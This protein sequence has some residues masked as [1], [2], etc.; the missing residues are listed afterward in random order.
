MIKL[1]LVFAISLSFTALPGALSKGFV[2]PT[3]PLAHANT[4]PSVAWYPAGPYMDTEVAPIFSSEGAEFIQLQA[5]T[6]DLT[7]W[8]LTPTLISSLG[9]N[10]SFFVTSPISAADEFEIQ[11]M[12]ATS[13]FG[14]NFN[15]GNPLPAPVNGLS[16]NCGQD[17]R[18]GIAHLIDRTNGANSFTSTESEI[19]GVSVPLN[20]PAPPATG[21][22]VPIVCG[23]D[24]LHVQST[25]CTVNS[26]TG[27]AYN[28]AGANGQCGSETAMTACSFTYQQG[29]KSSDFCAAAD[30]F[31]AAGLATGKDANC[32]L[33]GI[34][35]IAST[36]PITI[37]GRV[38]NPPRDHAGTAIFQGICA[39]FT[40]NF[41]TTSGTSC[42]I[43]PSTSNIISLLTHGFITSFSGF[44]TSPT[45]VSQ[46][47][48]IYTG[49]FNG[50]F[51]FTVALFNSYNSGIASA[52]CTSPGTTSCAPQV[53]GGGFCSNASVGSFGANDYQYM[54]SPS[55]D[56][57]SNQM[58]FAL[59]PSGPGDPTTG[60]S[61]S[62][63]TFAACAS[64]GLGANDFALSSGST[65]SGVVVPSTGLT[66]TVPVCVTAL[67]TFSGS[68]T[69]SA[70]S[71]SPTTAA[72]AFNSGN[73]VTLTNG[74]YGCL[75]LTIT[76]T[77]GVAITAAITVSLTIGATTHTL[78]LNASVAG[79]LYSFDGLRPVLTATSAGYITA[80]IGGKEAYTIP[81]WADKSQFGYSSKYNGVIN[82]VGLGI[83]QFNTWLNAFTATPNSNCPT[84]SPRCI[85]QGF[86]ETTHS[87]SP[88]IGN[89]VWDF[90]VIGNIYDSLHLGNPSALAQSLDYQTV[91][92]KGPLAN[93]A[94]TYTPPAG[95]T[96]TYS[97]TLR[98]D[99]FWQDGSK[100][101]SW[102]VA[103][104][105]LTLKALGA[106]QSGGL[107]A[108][109]GITI[110]GA[111]QF[112]INLNANGPFTLLD[113]TGQTVIP[114]EL[115]STCASSW[116]SDVASGSVPASCYTGASAV[117][118]A[119]TGP[120]FDPTCPSNFTNSVGPGG[121]NVCVTTN[122]GT[123]PQK[124]IFMG[125]SAWACISAG[126]LLGTSCST[127]GSQNP[128]FG[129]AYTLQRFGQ[130][131]GSPPVSC[132][133]GST[134]TQGYFRSS[135]NLALS[136]WSGDVGDFTHDFLNF[137]VVAAC[138]G[139]PLTGGSTGCG[140]WQEGIGGTVAGVPQTITNIQAGI[141]SRF[142]G[143][144]PVAPF[145]WYTYTVGTTTVPAN[146]PTN[147]GSFPPT[148][149]EG[150]YT[151]TPAATAG[152]TNAYN[153]TSTTSGGY[154]C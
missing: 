141:V 119:F 8:P 139:K 116:N 69:L 153:P 134:L 36:D 132:L 151:M 9:S 18:Q 82:N 64:A 112:D 66:D 133:P 34:N 122:G 4:A 81:L 108:M 43:A 144:N 109:T 83:P 59:C 51:P 101:T 6:I 97:F 77:G 28:L 24:S 45:S 26:A 80:D 33:T 103:F 68:G 32:V 84:S 130:T 73:S 76:L 137:G 62:T 7:D 72:V 44:T 57:Y 70:S 110:H 23:W 95:T 135:G 126:G 60:E 107:T 94:L 74:K 16:V 39:L 58:E 10:P 104:S 29:F 96:Q 40:G 50:E 143:V 145:N 115:W 131:C 123:T 120:T 79:G 148:L 102:D 91:S 42:G 106:F 22:P 53:V 17:I 154:D 67:G 19:A 92:T 124:G 1:L 75:P 30:D 127:S 3:V 99:M 14:C 38:D 52:S 78:T 48:H 13:F 121:A 152:C 140:H 35:S 11:F 54:C 86:K 21:L 63:V 105:D 100:V 147:L 136:I 12:E 15:F 149:L 31:I 118:S 47:W 55:Y 56:S 146:P 49:G 114:G 46:S 117:N 89:T 2:M 61:S 142:A 150:Q 65:Y 138:F 98:N 111:T 125:S 129:A 90:F 37:F 113:I 93:S 85:I 88:Y 87:L 71:S 41:G 20:I 27:F 128:P 5:G 25:G